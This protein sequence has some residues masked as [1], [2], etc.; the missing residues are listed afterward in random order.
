MSADNHLKPYISV[1]MG[2]E[3]IFWGPGVMMILEALEA[4]GSMKEACKQCGLSYSKAWKILNRAEEQLG[5]PVIIRQQGGSSGGGS[6]ITDLGRKLMQKYSEAQKRI[7]TYSEQVFA[8]VFDDVIMNKKDVLYQVLGIRTDDIITLTGAGGKTSMLFRLG[9]ELSERAVLLTTTTKM[10]YPEEKAVDYAYSEAE[11]RSHLLQ[12]KKGRTFLYG[13][14]N[15]LGKCTTL[16]E[17]LLVKSCTDYDITII[18]ADG[19]RRLPLKGYLADEPCIPQYATVN[20]GILTLN[21]LYQYP[22]SEYVLRAPEFREMVSMNETEQ[23]TEKHLASWI[24]HPQGLFKRSF[25]RRVLFFNQIEQA[26]QIYQVKQIVD[27]LDKTFKDELNLVVAGSIKNSQYTVLG[28][29]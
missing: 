12:P 1:R 6:M 27:Y 9:N 20:I 3:E 5:F 2:W 4:T 17:E 25:G 19:S 8:D 10:R 16:S 24:S 21:G 13:K 11:L 26:E 7:V 23:I 18:E 28:G 15:E 14:V 29:E 22:T